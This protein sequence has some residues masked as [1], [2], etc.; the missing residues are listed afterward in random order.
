MTHYNKFNF[1]NSKALKKQKI[2]L[3]QCKINFYFTHEHQKWNFY[4]W[5]RHSWKYHFW[6]SFGEIKIDLTL[7]KS[8]ILYAIKL[9]QAYCEFFLST[10]HCFCDFVLFN[11]ISIISGR[12][13][14]KNG[15]LYATEF[16]LRFERAPPPSRFKSGTALSAD[17]RLTHWATGAF[18]LYK[19]K[20]KGAKRDT[21]KGASAHMQTSKSKI[22]L[23]TQAAWSGSF[24]PGQCLLSTQ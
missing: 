13:K 20:I 23:C 5:L 24:C 17:Q 1:C 8:N 15:R 19:Y 11:S 22:R 12:W 14:R 16:H 10:M 3:F 9:K 6:C 2:W 21:S 18:R 4:S 7:K